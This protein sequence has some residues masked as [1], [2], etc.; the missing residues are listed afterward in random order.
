M[1]RWTARAPGPWQGR[2]LVAQA[3]SSRAELTRRLIAD[4]PAW[5]SGVIYTL[6]K[7]WN[8]KHFRR[9]LAIRSIAVNG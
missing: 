4:D 3:K 9:G 5:H 6:E 1:K 7:A 8:K 2:V